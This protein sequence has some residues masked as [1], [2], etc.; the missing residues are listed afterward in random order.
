MDL[1]RQIT[2]RLRVKLDERLHRR[3]RRPTF[4]SG[5][6]TSIINQPRTQLLVH[7]RAQLLLLQESYKGHQQQRHGTYSELLH[8]MEPSIRTNHNIRQ[9]IPVR[10]PWLHPHLRFRNGLFRNRFLLCPLRMSHLLVRNHQ[11]FLHPRLTVVSSKAL[12]I[13]MCNL[14]PGVFI[15]TTS[16]R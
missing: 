2:L 6:Q 16:M 10:S 14:P 11:G 4:K 1:R 3:H 13:T 15:S 5:L 9:M 8:L 12:V 7:H